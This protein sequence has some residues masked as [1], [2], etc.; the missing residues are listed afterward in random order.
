MIPCRALVL[1]THDM[2][3]SNKCR[4]MARHWRGHHWC[5]SMRRP[6]RLCVWR[7]PIDWSRSVHLDAVCMVG[8]PVCTWAARACLHGASAASQPSSNNKSKPP[9]PLDLRLMSLSIIRRDRLGRKRSQMPDWVVV[10]SIAS[11]DVWCVGAH[12]TGLDMPRRG[13]RHAWTMGPIDRF[14]GNSNAAESRPLTY[15]QFIWCIIIQSNQPIRSIDPP[16]TH[17]YERA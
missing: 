2:P 1:T 10:E 17:P 14:E 9:G 4:R 15:T 3:L 5:G 13:S 8:I 12:D 16:Q 6:D 7:G 11:T